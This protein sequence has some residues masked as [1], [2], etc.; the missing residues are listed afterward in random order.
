MC[1]F[2]LYKMQWFIVSCFAVGKKTAQP[3]KRTSFLLHYSWQH[4]FFLQCQCQHQA[5]PRSCETVPEA[6]EDLGYGQQRGQ[7]GVHC[8]QNNPHCH[9]IQKQWEGLVSEQ[10]H[11]VTAG[12]WYDGF[13]INDWWFGCM[14]WQTQRSKCSSVEGLTVF[15]LFILTINLTA[16]FHSLASDEHKKKNVRILSDLNLDQDRPT[17]NPLTMRVLTDFCMY[18]TVTTVRCYH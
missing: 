14:E 15:Y 13:S 11:G 17:S 10:H 6:E 3:H 9:P 8:I 7:C 1:L 16:I 5:L 12:H 4:T 18:L 2:F